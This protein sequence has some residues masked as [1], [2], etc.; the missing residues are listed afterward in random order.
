M[1]D[2]KKE[3]Q[4]WSGEDLQSIEHILGYAG[5]LMSFSVIA[6]YFFSP[7]LSQYEK[8]EIITTKTQLGHTIFSTIFVGSGF[9]LG[10]DNTCRTSL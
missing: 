3:N 4:R 1:S 6:A 8:Q 2:M 10:M 7:P 5:S 9:I